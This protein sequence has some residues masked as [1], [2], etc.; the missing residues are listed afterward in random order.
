[1]KILFSLK[2]TQMVKDVTSIRVRYQETDKMGI[3]YHGNYFTWLEVARI[4]LL[5]SINCPYSKL[6]EEGY[7]LPVISCS[8]EFKN[9]AKFDDRIE[10]EVCLPELG[11]V[12]IN[13]EYT[14][15]R[16]ELILARA[17]TSHAFVNEHGKVVRPPKDFVNSA[18]G[19]TTLGDM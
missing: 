2:S 1:M 16:D 3:A 19:E 17:K 14:L 5:D 10:I 8:C 7:F 15:R 9:P 13:L 4:H 6:E 12:R 11:Q 18:F